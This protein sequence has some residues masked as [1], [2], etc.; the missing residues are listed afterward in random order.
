MWALHTL[1][2]SLLLLPRRLSRERALF[3]A[4]H[5][6]NTHS[7]PF[8]QFT[9]YMACTVQQVSFITL[10]CLSWLCSLFGEF[11]RFCRAWSSLQKSL[12]A[13][14]GGMGVPSPND[15]RGSANMC[16]HL[17]IPA[18]SRLCSHKRN[19]I[20]LCLFSQLPQIWSD[21]EVPCRIEMEVLNKRGLFA[22]DYISFQPAAG[23]NSIFVFAV[24]FLKWT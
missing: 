21:I 5:S 7:H 18:R 15:L 8:L 3:A 6:H 1:H 11:G 4:F 24:Y 2:S 14:P 12:L 16:S 23:W 9:S 10:P 20:T 13:T 17:M 19:E 22:A